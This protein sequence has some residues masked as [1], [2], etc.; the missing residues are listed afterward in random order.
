MTGPV[1]NRDLRDVAALVTGASGTI[2]RATCA[3]LMDAGARVMATDLPSAPR[4]SEV[5]C[6]LEH[7]A[8]SVEAWHRVVTDTRKRFGRLDCL[9]N[10]A[11]MCPI[12]HIE[13]TS[14]ELWRKVSSVNVESILIGMQ[15]SLPVLRECGKDRPGGSSIVNLASTAGLRGVAF[16]AAY[17]ASKGAVT[18]LSK[19]AAKEFAALKYP[20][21]VN[22]VHPGSVDSEMMASNLDRLVQMGLAPSIEAAKAKQAAG[23]PM[24]RMARAEEVAGGIVFLCSPAAAFM[25][26]AEFVIDGGVTA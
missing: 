8:T 20:V 23:N 3:A 26:G 25:T 2:G 10:C 14:L 12:T 24:G 19:A 22:S 21:R 15:T 5:D 18:L 16:A 7:D 1:L 17:C 13:E 4:N 11:G 9:I 6:W